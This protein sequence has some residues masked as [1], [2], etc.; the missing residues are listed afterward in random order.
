MNHTIIIAGVGFKYN[1]SFNW[2][3]NIFE[4][5]DIKQNI[6]LAVAK[7]LAEQNYNIILISKTQ[8]KLDKIKKDIKAIHPTVNIE[9]Y[10]MDL[11]KKLDIV[12]FIGSLSSNTSYSLVHSAGL[13][14]GGYSLKEDNPYL[15]LEEIPDDLPTL[16]FN[17]V[18]KSFLLMMQGLLPKFRS[19]RSSRVI[20]INSM[21]GIRPYPRGFSHSS[22]KAGL[23]NAIRSLTLELACDNI[24]FSEINPG[25]VSTGSYDSEAVVES[26]KI[27]SEKFGYSYDSLPSISPRSVAE[28]VLFCLKNEANVMTINLLPNDQW[29]NQGA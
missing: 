24:Y 11:L 3:E 1:E 29:K 25:I 10:S 22:A 5:E 23:H 13:S 16:E 17:A 20:V 14:A 8:E 28:A 15:P 2:N 19:Q 7:L 12:Q 27:I 18:V 26:V 4:S 21:S 6:G 9:I